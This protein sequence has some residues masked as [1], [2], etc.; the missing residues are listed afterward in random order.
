MFS[1]NMARSYTN[2]TRVKQQ[3]HRL[4]KM[5]NEQG[6]E[7]FETLNMT[8]RQELFLH[9]TTC[10]TCRHAIKPLNEFKRTRLMFSEML[11]RRECEEMR[12]RGVS[13][14]WRAALHCAWI[15]VYEKRQ[16]H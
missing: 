10:T 1:T 11:E 4:Q 6:L 15:P 14:R 12:S 16:E 5:E 9:A 3:R 7:D 13:S 8:D 2:L